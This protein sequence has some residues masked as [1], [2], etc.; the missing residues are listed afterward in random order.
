MVELADL[1]RLPIDETT[2][3]LASLTSSASEYQH[4]I[5]CRHTDRVGPFLAC[6]YLRHAAP[7]T[8]YASQFGHVLRIL[9]IYHNVEA[10]L[11]VFV[12]SP[13]PIDY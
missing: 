11:G 1:V 12:S 5:A 13:H 4:E 7:R 6:E 10:V 2:F 3:E 8:R 9:E